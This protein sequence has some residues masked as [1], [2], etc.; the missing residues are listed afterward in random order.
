MPNKQDATSFGKK[1]NWLKNTLS[2]TDGEIGA[3]AGAS[4]PL[5][6]RWRNGERSLDR[7]RDIGALQKLVDYFLRVAD[8]RGNTAVI[9]NALSV[10]IDTL[11]AESILTFMFDGKPIMTD[12]EDG[13]SPPPSPPAGQICYFGMDGI[14]NAVSALG[15]KMPGGKSEIVVYLSLEHAGILREPDAAR[16]WDALVHINGDRPVRVVF[17][18]WSNTATG[19]AAKTLLA[20]MS[21]ASKG[22]LRLHLVKSTQKFFYNNISFFAGGVGMVIT[23]GPV[24]GG[25]IISVP[26]DSPEYISGVGTLFAKLDRNTKPVD[27]H[28][29][30][31]EASY[32]SRLYEP[33]GDVRAVID[34]ANLLYL[35]AD[36]YLN[37][38]KLNGI[39]CSRRTYRM[40]KFQKDKR[41]FELFLES[42][43]VTEIFS[44]KA[45]DRMIAERKMITPDF[46]FLSCGVKVTAEILKSLFSGMTDALERHGNLSVYLNRQGLP[47]TYC[48]QRL[49][50]DS[51]ALLHSYESGGAH[52]V[53][54]DTWLAV[55]EY[56]RQF[57]EAAQ[58][59]EL[60]TTSDAVKTAL[61]IRTESLRG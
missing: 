27:K 35:D 14:L 29:A 56:I 22:S 10:N 17:D 24:I 30:K 46:S 28:L 61:K 21:F 6:C 33:S 25:G 40:E 7:I 32:Y 8:K 52:A 57:D 20:L 44:L 49:K 54:T 45:F 18:T 51:F 31:D 50:G 39:A 13:D 26:V 16:L 42:G 23:A 60:I 55:Y 9:A 43:R 47:Q 1:L 59:T 4:T 12:D 48:S 15:E 3:A 2:V 41:Q 53:Y 36:A 19:E 58:D 34:G 5:V 11:T 37:L 38:L